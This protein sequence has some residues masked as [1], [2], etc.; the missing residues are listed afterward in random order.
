MTSRTTTFMNSRIL[1]FDTETT[2]L[3]KDKGLNAILQRGNWPD[4]VSISWIVYDKGERVKKESHIIR[5]QGWFIPADAAKIH[6]ITDEIAN[7]QGEGLRE[8]LHAFTADLR[9][10]NYVVAHNME[11]DRNVL[12]A[13]YKWRLAADPR[14]FWPYEAEV[15]TMVLSRDELRLPAKYPKAND[16]YKLPRLDELYEA[17]FATKAPSGAHSAD[18]DTEV[19]TAIFWARWKGDILSPYTPSLE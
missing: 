9:G 5:P 16:P 6:G 12:H 14:E 13:A 4:L 8:V 11:F 3:P 10:C 1:F 18:R 17:T 15:C 19:L 2:G 7:I